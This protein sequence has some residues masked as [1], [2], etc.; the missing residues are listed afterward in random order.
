V[1]A[2]A[3]PTVTASATTV[4]AGMQ[5]PLETFKAEEERVMR[6]LRFHNMK[7]KPVCATDGGE[8]WEG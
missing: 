8:W 4:V 5:S 6:R 2:G 1:I 7:R 3:T